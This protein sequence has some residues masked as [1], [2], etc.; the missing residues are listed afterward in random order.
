MQYDA[1]K[2]RNFHSL[3]SWSETLF[4]YT[5]LNPPVVSNGHIICILLWCFTVSTIDETRESINT[6]AVFI[7]TTVHP[8]I[9]WIQSFVHI[10]WCP[11]HSTF[12]IASQWASIP[13]T[14][15]LIS[16][17]LTLEKQRNV[18]FLTIN[19]NL[20]GYP[21]TKVCKHSLWTI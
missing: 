19:M 13:Q 14:W 10:A 5:Q 11:S 15:S 21:S 12:T 2:L 6:Y 3:T 18:T 9:R 1:R 4:P 8:W 20:N 17:I 7:L 16:S